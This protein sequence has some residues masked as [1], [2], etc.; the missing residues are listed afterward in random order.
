VPGAYAVHLLSSTG[1]AVKG[2]CGISV[3][4]AALSTAPPEQFDGFFV[5]GGH[6]AAVVRTVA[7]IGMRDWVQAAAAQHRR[8]GS[9]CSGSVILAAWD[10]IGA[11]RFATHWRAVAE[12]HRRWPD[13]DVDPEAIFVEDGALWTSAGVSTGIDMALAIVERDHGVAVAQAI[14]QRLVLAARRPGWQ[15]QF[16]PMLSAQAMADGRYADLIAW[17]D[18]HLAAPISVE[19]MAEHCHESLRSFHRNFTAAQGQAP[20]QFLTRRRVDRARLLLGQGM[21]LKQVA[22]ATGFADAAHLSAAFRRTVGLSA[23]EWQIVHGKGAVRGA[24]DGA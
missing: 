8:Y 13:L 18:A 9:I 24:G 4:T 17:L 14:A 1:G 15:S 2:L 12:V 16:S 5:T 6:A 22:T 20:A 23:R 7:D 21:A 10:V 3:E 19:A 11:R